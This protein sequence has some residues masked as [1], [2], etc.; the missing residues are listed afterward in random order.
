MKAMPDNAS[1]RAV[2]L[3]ASVV[4][5]TVLAIAGCAAT[6]MHPAIPKI[7]ESAGWQLS[8]GCRVYRLGIPT[9]PDCD[10]LT[11]QDIAIQI[12]RIRVLSLQPGQ[13]DRGT[14]GIEFQPDHGSWSF[15]APYAAL[16]IAGGSYTPSDLDEAIVFAKEGATIVQRLQP[17]QQRY[18]LPPGEKR[19]LRLRFA[20]TQD[21]LGNGFALRVT[22]LQ[23]DGEAVR[24]PLLKFETR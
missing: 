16:L 23:K 3:G 2:S 20:V 4:V 18:E 21:K 24:V 5:V 17:H 1:G 10:I 9:D 12:T 19:F 22:G 11:G 6:R 8:E 15:S 14:I 7:E 13:D